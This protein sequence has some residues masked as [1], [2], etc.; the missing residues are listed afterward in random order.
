MARG[1]C[2]NAPAILAAI[3]LAAATSARAAEPDRVDVEL[4]VIRYAG[5]G[6]ADA[7]AAAETAAAVLA[8]AGIAARWRECGGGR[9]CD[10]P[11]ASR[12]IRVHL[13]PTTKAADP[14]A[15][16]DAVRDAE[17]TLIV[18]VYLPAVSTV[19]DAVRRSPAGRS[20]PALSTVTAGHVV[21]ITI[22]HEI[23]HLLGLT[24]SA[25]G[26]MKPRL[27][28]DDLA[29]ARTS[30]LTFHPEE[31]RRILSALEPLQTVRK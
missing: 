29:A 11:H 19:V 30:G 8:S 21:G 6:D 13:L 7:Q 17:G 23:G 10:N 1:R 3:G 24:H 22:A 12:V 9:R 27:S 4:R 26:V 25:A 5:L 2:T 16:G 15:S 18:L 28:A 31:R 14:G 20:H